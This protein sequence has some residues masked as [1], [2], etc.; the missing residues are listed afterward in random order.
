MFVIHANWT[1]GH[2]HIWAESL[3]QFNALP[4]DSSSSATS[5]GQVALV[6]SKSTLS[7]N[8][9]VQSKD[10]A[11]AIIGSG[12]DLGDFKE[13]TLSLKLPHNLLGP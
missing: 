1:A 4:V 5:N 7:H 10:I 12:I 9:A 8:F 13:E 2:L 6:N 11:T 3:D